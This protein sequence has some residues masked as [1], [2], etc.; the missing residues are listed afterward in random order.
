MTFMALLAVWAVMTLAPVVFEN[1]T[2]RWFADFYDRSIY[3]ERGKWFT[4]RTPP[5]SEYPQIPTLLFGLNNIPFMWLNEKT[6]FAAYVVFF[7]LE[8]ML[9]LFLTY[10]TLLSLLP[11]AFKNYAFLVF[12]PATL[13]F[14][15]NRFDILPAYLCLAAYASATKRRWRATSILLA[16]ATFTKWYPILLFPAFFVYAAKRESRLPWTMLLWF[17][18]IS[19]TLLLLTYLCGGSVSILAPYQFQLARGMEPVALPTQVSELI[20]NL[21]GARSD[22]PFLLPLFFFLQIWTPM[23]VFIARIETPESLVDYCIIAIGMFVLFSR[24]WSPQWFL[25]LFPFLVISIGSARKALLIVLCD[26]MTYLC[27]PILFDSYG[28][29]SPQLKITGLLTLSIILLMVLDS[30]RNLATARG[31]HRRLSSV[32][33]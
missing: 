15:Y 1:R 9:V 30:F 7:S 22:P 11:P 32:G 6:R 26:V 5:I 24:I 29:S 16:I 31:D 23:L 8:M 12:L 10:K 4:E 33:A 18:V 21:T 3:F 14:T 2:G 28:P 20:R 17:G 25:W 19:I 13:Y 27:F